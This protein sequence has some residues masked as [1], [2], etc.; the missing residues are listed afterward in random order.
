M[1]E[2]RETKL[3]KDMVKEVQKRYPAA[4]VFKVHGNPYQ[5]S[6]VPDLLI[7]LDGHLFGIE[8]KAPGRG[9]T[10]EH[11]RSRTT[12]KQE[13]ELERLSKAGATTGVAVTVEEMIEIIKGAL[14]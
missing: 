14:P 4:W 6:G 9:E 7:C 10:D 8:V 13:I 12:T 3:V 11:A 5:R 2:Q 1:P